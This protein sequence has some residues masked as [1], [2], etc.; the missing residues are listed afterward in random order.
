ML[1]QISEPSYHNDT[2]LYDSNNIVVGIDLG[3]TNSLIAFCGEDGKPKIIL[4]AKGRSSE[5]SIVSYDTK[6]KAHVGFSIS[7][8]GNKFYSIKR[9]MGLSVKSEN[10]LSSN[11]VDQNK[12]ND[13]ICL[14]NIYDNKLTVEKISSEIL[15]SLKKRAEIALKKDVYQAV[16]TVPAYFDELARVATRKAASLAGL[17]V[18]RLINEPTAA[19]YAYGL[20]SSSEGVY[21]FYDWGG[22]TFDFSL[23]KLH[24]GVFQVLGTGGDTRLGGDDI[25]HAFLKKLS[26]ENNCENISLVDVQVLKKYLSNNNKVIFKGN[27]LSRDLLELVSLPFINKTIEIC[28]R[29]CFDAKINLKDIQGI[30]LVGGST[31][32]P[33]VRQVIKSVFRKKPIIDYNPETIVAIGAALQARSLTKGDNSLLLDVTPLSLGLETIGGIVEH[34]I[35]RNSVLPIQASQTFTTQKDGQTCIVFHIVQG[36]KKMAKDCRSLARF[37]LKGLPPRDAGSCRI[38]VIFSLDEDGILHVEAKDKSTGISHKVNVNPS[39][40]MSEG[41]IFNLLLDSKHNAFTDRN[42]DLVLKIKQQGKKIYNEVKEALHLDGDILLSTKEKNLIE[43]KLKLLQ[44][45][46]DNHDTKSITDAIESLDSSTKHYAKLRVIN[47]L[48]NLSKS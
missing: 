44:N 1:I 21:A 48:K 26:K 39:L 19:A 6:G 45:T 43:H 25:D 36:E 46:M 5:P 40:G 42:Q 20:E 30:V 18:L 15:K 31:R 17:K 37:E 33:L 16:I 12:N 4:D 10:K 38:N 34:L 14:K 27:L 29:V 2:K 23:L 11:L 8:Y 35:P 22:G 9:L 7:K 47:S 32:M 28:R 41:E 13:F 3:T 24:K